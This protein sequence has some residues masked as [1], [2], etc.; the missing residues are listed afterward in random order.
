VPV[1]EGGVLNFCHTTC[2]IFW[3]PERR[4]LVLVGCLFAALWVPW[5][6][7]EL[8]RTEWVFLALGGGLFTAVVAWAGRA[9]GRVTLRELGVL[10]LVA[11]LLHQFEEHGVDVLG[12]RYA[13]MADANGFL[14]PLLQCPPLTDCPLNAEAIYWV[15]TMLVW[16][17]LT[18]AAVLGRRALVLAGAGLTFSNAVA[19]LVAAVAQRQYN[20]GLLTGVLFFL[21]LTVFVCWRCARAFGARASTI[22][23]SVA[24]G[25]AGHALLGGLAFVV[26]TKHALPSVAYPGVLVTYGSLPLLVSRSGRHTH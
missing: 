9:P 7:L 26:Y 15:N 18:L 10:L 20:P 14:G 12:R 22:A 2:H 23:L 13:F 19:H 16:W 4:A 21:P 5:G 6:Q 25:A 3:V 24:W 11:Y 1:L 8:L 17:P